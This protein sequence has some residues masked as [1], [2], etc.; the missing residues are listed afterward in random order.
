MFEVKVEGAGAEEVLSLHE[1]PCAMPALDQG[2]RS[3]CRRQCAHMKVC[4]TTFRPVCSSHCTDRLLLARAAGSITILTGIDRSAGQ[5]QL[6]S[7]AVRP[8]CRRAA[9]VG[10]CGGHGHTWASRPHCWRS[11]CA[12]KVLP[13]CMCSVCMHPVDT[14]GSRAKKERSE[15]CHVRC[16]T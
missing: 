13:C 6:G 1:W 11:A 7:S 4:R 12:C 8:A 5:E 2:R 14:V 16:R 3:T 15:C 10:S 9:F